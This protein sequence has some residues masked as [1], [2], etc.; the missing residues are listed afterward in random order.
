MLTHFCIYWHARTSLRFSR[1]A[2]EWHH[3]RGASVTQLQRGVT[4]GGPEPVRRWHLRNPPTYTHTWRHGVTCA[5]LA[6]ELGAGWPD[7]WAST[8]TAAVALSVG[9]RL[10]EP[11]RRGQG[12]EAFAPAE[13]RTLEGAS[14]TKAARVGTGCG[15]E[16]SSPRVAGAPVPH[17]EGWR[18]GMT[19]PG[20]SPA[21]RLGRPPDPA[22]SPAHPHRLSSQ[23]VARPQADKDARACQRRSRRL[24][25][26]TLGRPRPLWHRPPIARRRSRSPPISGD[27]AEPGHPLPAV[28]GTPRPPGVWRWL[29]VRRGPDVDPSLLTAD[30]WLG[31]GK[32]L[33]VCQWLPGTPA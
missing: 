18:R 33:Q 26:T 27:E 17:R 12:R 20:E 5:A 10:G 16:G 23:L 2:T 24:W 31:Q 19:W 14:R 32:Q 1:Q 9:P 7:A 15:G 22:R 8:W 30:T 21:A 11:H 3:P 6:P 28:A 4:C 29:S 25:A 13:G